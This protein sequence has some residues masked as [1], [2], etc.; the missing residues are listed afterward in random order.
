MAFGSEPQNI[1]LWRL[2]LPSLAYIVR[3]DAL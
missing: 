2:H 3:D 1:M